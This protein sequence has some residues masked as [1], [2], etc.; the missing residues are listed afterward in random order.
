MWQPF[1][2][3]VQV[4]QLQLLVYLDDNSLRMIITPIMSIFTDWCRP[5]SLSIIIAELKNVFASW[6]KNVATGRGTQLLMLCISLSLFWL[7][8]QQFW[9]Q[10]YLNV[11]SSAASLVS[12]S[13]SVS[14]DTAVPAAWISHNKIITHV[15]LN[16]LHQW[17]QSFNFHQVWQNVNNQ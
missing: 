12:S 11:H 10:T 2:F 16:D 3:F 7:I 17:V 1:Y 13:W 5:C 8:E 9:C 14:S 15:T 4:F 6:H